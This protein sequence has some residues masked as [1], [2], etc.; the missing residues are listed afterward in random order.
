MKNWMS[1]LF[2]AVILIVSSLISLDVQASQ[3]EES[4][5]NISAER[6]VFIQ[7][8]ALQ[9]WDGRSVDEAL[10]QVWE[11]AHPRNQ[12]MTGPIE[13]FG[14]M[15]LAPSYEPLIGHQSH[16]IQSIDSSNNG[17]A[18]AKTAIF[19]VRVLAGNGNFYR[20]VWQLSMVDRPNGRVWLTSRVSPARSTG[21]Q[22]SS[23][24]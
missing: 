1:S 8:E 18:E 17:H 16:T 12:L 2:P 13:R 10:R 22:L 6:V 23:L 3:A 14:Q 7:L 5:P 15:L 21:E 24:F 4:Q 20:F 19:S 11:L 9:R